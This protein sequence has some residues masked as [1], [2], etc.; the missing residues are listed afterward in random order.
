MDG[1]S[2]QLQV[3]NLKQLPIIEE[4]LRDVKAKIE[5]RTS[6][7]MA[8]AVTEEN[9]AYAK[10]IR[11]ELRKELEGYEAQR[12][13]VKKAIMA[14][15]EQFE[16]VYK[17]CVSI[18][19]KKADADLKKKTDDIDEG[20]RKA[21]E[22]DVRA[23]FNELTSGF[24]LDWLKFEQMNLKVTLTCTPKAMKAA[25]TQSVTK[26][27]RDCAAL[28]ENPDRDEIMVEYQKS[29]DLGSA[30]QIVQQ[31]H[32]QLEAQR[33]AAEERRARQ[34]AQQEAE[35]KAKAA[36]EAEA[37]K[38]AVEQPAPPHEVAT[39]P[40]AE[41]PAQAPAAAPAPAAARAEKKY[42]AKF[43]VTG[44]LPQLKALKAFMEKEGMQYDTIS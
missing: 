8:L 22:D 3:I 9:S 29:L 38:R 5:Q 36:I 17:E 6:A 42:L 27:V 7:V 19:Y 25:I 33:R 44:T 11:T 12:M 21:K 34:Q 43:A 39:P 14:P 18:P 10:K 4:R 30:C 24:G 41:S 20:R 1:N 32:K 31:R 37:A 2:E 40:Q 15:Y 16:A 26:I 28:E 35:A 23:F 13:T